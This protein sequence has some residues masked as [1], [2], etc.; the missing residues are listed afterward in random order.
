MFTHNVESCAWQK[1]C[2]LTDVPQKQLEDNY[3]VTVPLFPPSSSPKERHLAAGSCILALRLETDGI[4]ASITS[5]PIQQGKVPKSRKFLI[6][7][8]VA[9]PV[10]V[11]QGLDPL[12]AGHAFNSVM[13]WFKSACVAP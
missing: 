8:T 2:A 9:N 12:D 5:E 13:T 3:G 1:I 4:S 10:F 11:E 7:G 6:K